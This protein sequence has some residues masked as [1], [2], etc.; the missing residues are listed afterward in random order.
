MH[1]WKIGPEHSF[2]YTLAPS[3]V[4]ELFSA[5]NEGTSLLFVAVTATEYLFNITEQKQL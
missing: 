3:E 2:R 4:E 5:R 1:I